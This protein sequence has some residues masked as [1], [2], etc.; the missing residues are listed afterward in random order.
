MKNVPVGQDEGRDIDRQV[1]RVLRELG[2]PQ[3]PLRLELVRDV[4]RLDRQFFSS[5]NSSCLDEI[6]SRLRRAGKQIVLRPTLL[7]DAVRK[8]KLSALWLPDGRRILIDD[9]IP[10]LKK[11]WAEGHE[12]GHSLAE[13]HRNYFL[14]DDS[15]TLSARC[16]EA[17]ENEANY[18]AGQLL[19]LKE[20]FL[21]EARDMEPSLATV[22]QLARTFG[23]T[24]TTTLWRFAEKSEFPTVGV[25]CG[26]PDQRDEDFD[27]LNPCKY[28][29]ESPSFRDRFTQSVSETNLYQIIRGYCTWRRG[30][31]LGEKET[32]LID[33]NGDGHVFHFE[34]HFNR[35]KPGGQQRGAAL[36]LAVYLRPHAAQVLVPG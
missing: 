11:R 15:Y 20:R 7:L 28:V 36:T 35:Y 16:D 13:W 10:D 8:A 32:V 30:G 27:P 9:E 23:N 24:Q 12:I 18:G 21:A 3:P 14:G 17:L 33:E 22:R 4:E 19:F 2:N 25:V 34:T 5:S 6:V 26:H 1:A 31:P 29:I